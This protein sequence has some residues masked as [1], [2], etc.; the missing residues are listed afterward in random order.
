MTA[1]ADRIRS[2]GMN[3]RREF[4]K[5]TGLGAAALVMPRSVQAASATDKPN[6]VIIVADDLG[7]NDVGFHGGAINTPDLD[8]LA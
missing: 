3:T 2:I 5:T 8:R 4:L 1:A 6:I 7:W